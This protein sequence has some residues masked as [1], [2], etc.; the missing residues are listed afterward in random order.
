MQKIH[1]NK[2]RSVQILSLFCL[3][4][5]ITACGTS[6]E[7]TS[8]DVPTQ[9]PPTGGTGVAT[10]TW[11]APTLNDDGSPALDYPI[12]DYVY[13]GLRDAY[14]KIAECQF[15]AGAKSVLPAHLKARSYTSWNEAKSAISCLPMN[16]PDLYLT[17][18]HVLGGCGIGEDPE[19]SVINSNGKHH[20]L[21]NLYV[22]DGSAF[23]TSLGVNPL[24]SICAVAA[25]WATQ[26]AKELQNYTYPVEKG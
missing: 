9:P 11:T 21:S 6:S 10:L 7:T 15:A 18:A 25:R 14:L 22:I 23:P 8:N 2:T 20:Q 17:S 5:L 26:L 3:A 19:T 16:I 4:L 12:T 1:S 13:E 24:V